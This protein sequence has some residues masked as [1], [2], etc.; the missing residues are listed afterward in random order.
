MQC[1]VL[2]CE[3]AMQCPV[4]AYESAMRYPVLTYAQVSMSVFFLGLNCS[5]WVSSSAIMLCV[6][7]AM[8]GTD[9]RAAG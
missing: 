2:A 1:P 3:S 5:F 8:P 7:Y 6:C 9:V 4:L